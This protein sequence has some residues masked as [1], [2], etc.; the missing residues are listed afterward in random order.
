M[1]ILFIGPYRQLDGWGYA[2][3]DYAQSLLTTEHNISIKPIYMANVGRREQL[4]EELLLAEQRQFDNI[5]VVIQNVIPQYISYLNVPLNIAYGNFETKN[6]PP[7]WRR[8]LNIADALFTSTEQEKR[9]LINEGYTK[10]IF[11]TNNGMDI[12]K[13]EKAL[14]VEEEMENSEFYQKFN[15]NTNTFKFY[16]VG[17]YIQRKNVIDL[18]LA[19]YREFHFREDVDLVIKT[20]RGGVV[21]Y[22]LRS[23]VHSDINNILQAARIYQ[24][25]KYY[26]QP[27]IITESLS[28]NNLNALH[29]K[30][31]CFVMPSYGESLCRPVLDAIGFGSVPIVS[32]ATGMTEYVTNDIGWTVPTMEVPVFTNEPPMK[33]IYTAKETWAKP[34]VIQLQRAMREAYDEHK[35]NHIIHKQIKGLDVIKR[36]SYTEVGKKITQA[37]EK[38]NVNSNR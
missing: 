33:T 24:N 27:I 29:K 34:D 11:C 30:C 38:L 12:S 1:N 2:A 19:F 5:D 10:P 9:Q 21:D 35:N 15:L 31:H 28:E 18:V 37:I 6:L 36:F 32:E 26:K 7:T 17:E 3:C 8:S 20:N 14:T 23:K 16:F 4:S 13:Y 22:I 25:Q